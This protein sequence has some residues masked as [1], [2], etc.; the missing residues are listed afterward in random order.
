[1]G[2]RGGRARWEDAVGGRAPHIADQPNTARASHLRCVEHGLPL[3]RTPVGWHRQGALGQSRAVLTLGSDVQVVQQH[4]EDLDGREGALAPEVVH[5]ISARVFAPEQRLAPCHAP[6]RPAGAQCGCALPHEAPP[7]IKCHHRR[8]LPLC[9]LIGDN[10]HATTPGD[11]HHRVRAAHI[12]AER[13]GGRNCGDQ[14]GETEPAVQEQSH[15]LASVV[16]RDGKLA[17]GLMSTDRQQGQTRRAHVA[18]TSTSTGT[19]PPLQKMAATVVDS[20]AYITLFM[21]ACKFPSR[22]VNGLLLGSVSDGGVSVQKALPLFHTPLGLA[23]MLEAALMLVRRLR[24]LAV[25]SLASLTHP[26]CTGRPTSTARRTRCKWWAITRPTSCATTW[27]SGRSARPL[28]RRSARSANMRQCC[29]CVPLPA[30]AA[31]LT[32]PLGSC[33]V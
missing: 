3:C 2:A 31:A 24:T 21:H 19:P 32:C 9:G 15:F 11:S 26:C 1:M 17:G 5:L 18:F 14:G 23:P 30:F 8:R 4:R 27:S 13:P 16:A 28:R 6:T 33:L 25:V 29:W 10:I 22:T 20:E 7:L 12:N